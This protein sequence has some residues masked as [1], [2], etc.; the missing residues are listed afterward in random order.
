MRNCRTYL[1][2]RRYLP[3][4]DKLLFPVDR[5]YKACDYTFDRKLILKD[6]FLLAKKKKINNL[7]T[8]IT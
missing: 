5:K 3:I 2:V 7:T 6:T 8:T 4:N 1:T